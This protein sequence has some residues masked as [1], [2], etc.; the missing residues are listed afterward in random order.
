MNT[1]SP[2]HHCIGNPCYICY[3]SLRPTTYEPISYVVPPMMTFTI[4]PATC[5]ENV[6]YFMF[7]GGDVPEGWKC[8]C[9]KTAYTRVRAEAEIPQRSE[10]LQPQTDGEAGTPNP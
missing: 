2:A 1:T 6:H 8:D 7:A 9:G 4:P 10:E 5:H 3:P